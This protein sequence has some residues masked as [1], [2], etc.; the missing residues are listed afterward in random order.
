MFCTVS[1]HGAFPH[2]GMGLGKIQR[3]RTLGPVVSKAFSLND[4]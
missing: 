2:G 4:G 1:L 3:Q